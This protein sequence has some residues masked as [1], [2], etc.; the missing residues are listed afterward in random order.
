M[1]VS[2]ET[3][4]G[5]APSAGG[6]RV[7]KPLFY[8]WHRISSSR[9]SRRRYPIKFSN[10]VVLSTA[11]E[12]VDVAIVALA[13]S[14]VYSR[15]VE[16]RWQPD[17]PY[18]LAPFVIAAIYTGVSLGLRQYRAIKTRPLHTFAWS[19]IGAVAL[20]FSFYLSTLFLF[21]LIGEYSRVTLLLQFVGVTLSIIGLR[22]TIHSTARTAISRGL[23]RPRRA[24]LIGGQSACGWLSAAL[25]ESNVRTVA[26]LPAFSG[27]E[28]SGQASDDEIASIV[29]VCRDLHPDD[30]ILASTNPNLRC[31]QPLARA[32]SELPVYVHIS[33]AGPA[34]L[35]K[36]AHVSEIGRVRT[37][38][39]SS[40]PLSASDQALK[41]AFDLTVAVSAIIILAPLMLLI[42]AAVRATSNGP[43]LYRQVRHGFNNEEILVWKFRTMHVCDE[44]EKFIQAV[45]G[46]PR[47]TALGKI[48]RETNM[49]ELP[50]L[51][52]VLAGNMS[53][54]GPRP[55][56]VAHNRIF[57]KL[58]GSFARRHNV[59]PGLTGWAQVNGCRGP[60]DTIEKMQRRIDY[61]LLYLD[62]WSLLLD[63][64]IV[65]L[66]LFSKKSYEN[67]C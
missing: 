24:V 17:W 16:S 58:I 51:F 27:L 4:S 62:S 2:G 37:I 11:I 67:A 33:P 36:R 21:K 31:I 53:I 3:S 40:K 10:L 60:T 54:V 1:S 45:P 57:E 22:G 32:L 13:S 41:R 38:V 23:V 12:F 20:S 5:I 63:F 18:L 66:T 43:A 64:K 28:D 30:V 50:Q 29:N 44:A 42:A 6:I 34:V 56:A 9:S 15:L 14:V 7:A 39:T 59:R 8:P 49:D 26:T 35:L 47:I 48:L 55:H 61:D 19:G 52:N 65:I 46:D 25:R